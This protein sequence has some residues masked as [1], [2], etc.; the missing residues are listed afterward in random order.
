MVPMSPS[1]VNIS[2]ARYAGVPTRDTCV[3]IME[4]MLKIFKNI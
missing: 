2:G 1:C 3:N 4:K